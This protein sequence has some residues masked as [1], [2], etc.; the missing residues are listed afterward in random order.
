[1]SV[2]RRGE[3]WLA[4]FGKPSG[5]EQA[6][7]RP[8]VLIQVD[9]LAHLTTV[10]VVP[11]TTTIKRAGQATVV[12]IPAT[13]GGLTQV[14]VALCHQIRALDRRKLMRKLGELKAERMSEIE[15]AIAFVVGIPA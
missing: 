5:H 1:M 11:V 12:S 7:I 3:V 9:D 2:G 14:S 8:A 4:D 13:E 15:I 6:F 10:V